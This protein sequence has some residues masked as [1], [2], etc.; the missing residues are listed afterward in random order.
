M[1]PILK[2]T[3]LTAGEYL[4]AAARVRVRRELQA[5]QQRFNF[6]PVIVARMYVWVLGFR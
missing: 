4:S 1:A 2:C 6:N 3:R 5:L